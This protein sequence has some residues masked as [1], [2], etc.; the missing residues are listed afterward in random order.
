M[1]KKLH[2]ETKYYICLV[3]S[4]EVNDDHVCVFVNS[5]T[6]VS[7]TA[8][9]KPDVCPCT[10]RVL[11]YTPLCEG[12]TLV[13]VYILSPKPWHICLPFLNRLNMPPIGHSD[14][15]IKV[16]ELPSSTILP[17]ATVMVGGSGVTE[18]DNC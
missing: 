10:E 14:W 16:T 18:M 6:T 17:G 12:V 7:P 2:L 15:M 5:P 13:S 4:P 3:H 1:F 8:S 11:L 9:L